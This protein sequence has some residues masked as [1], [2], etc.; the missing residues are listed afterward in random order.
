MAEK[1]KKVFFGRAGTLLIHLGEDDKNQ[2]GTAHVWMDRWKLS[3]MK[4]NKLQVMKTAP[5]IVL[6]IYDIENLLKADIY[7]IIQKFLEPQYDAD[8]LY[9]YSA[10]KLSGQSCKIGLFADS[11]KEFIPGKIIQFRRTSSET[12]EQ[13]KLD[14]KLACVEG[15]LQYLRDR[16][17]GFANVTAIRGIPALPY[18]IAATDHRG[19]MVKLI[20]HLDRER[21]GGAISRNMD[22]LTLK[23]YLNDADSVRHYSYTY[24][25]TLNEFRPVTFEELQ[26]EYPHIQQ[27]ETDIILDNEAKFFVW[28]DRD[29]WGFFVLPVTR[30]KAELMVGIDKFFPFESDSWV[31]NFFDGTR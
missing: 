18:E 17:Y 6:N 20:H 27:D 3:V 22:D 14:M 24:Q 29:K 11:I 9:D 4:D 1:V 16:K 10:I 7:G 28:A 26:K 30:I 12:D 19:Q 23:L 31:L 2:D 25:C 8:K 5:D 13:E 21:N 15:A